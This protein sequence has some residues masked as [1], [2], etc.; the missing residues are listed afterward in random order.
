M[1][2][3]LSLQLSGSDMTRDAVAPLA[4]ALSQCTSMKHLEIDM[5]PSYADDQCRS[6]FSNQGSLVPGRVGVLCPAARYDDS[7][8]DLKLRP[9]KSL[10]LR[11]LSCG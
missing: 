6:L 8:V 11:S 3:E 5:S 2:V 4:N 7:G 9:A 1:L 10:S